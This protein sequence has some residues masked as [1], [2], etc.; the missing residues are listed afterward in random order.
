MT[1][2]K[3]FFL[4]PGQLIIAQHN[5]EVVTILGSCVTI[6]L[7]SSRAGISAVNHAQQPAMGSQLSCRDSCPHPCGKAEVPDYKY[8]TCSMDFMW[9][10]LLK[11]GITPG[12]LQVSLYG[13]ATSE[14]MEGNPYNVGEKNI[15]A[16]ELAIAARGLKI[17][18]RDVGGRLSRK[19]R[20]DS[21]SGMTQI[22]K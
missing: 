12:E 14:V 17:H 6:I 21:A 20:H 15:A 10:R 18:H 4:Y 9:Q 8:V 19:L 16:A 13:G 5:E 3:Q 22:S 7:H 1:S 2:G 11:M